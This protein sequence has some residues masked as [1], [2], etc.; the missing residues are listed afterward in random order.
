[1]CPKKSFK[2]ILRELQFFVYPGK[3]P[4]LMYFRRGHDQLL[5]AG[6]LLTTLGVDRLGRSAGKSA[7][8][9]DDSCK[10][11]LLC[12]IAE[13]N[14]YMQTDIESLYG[15]SIRVDIRR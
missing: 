11:C 4:I 3:T 8:R 10:S 14:T 13:E 15:S 2:V 9:H 1:M 6:T 5:D 12:T 7:R